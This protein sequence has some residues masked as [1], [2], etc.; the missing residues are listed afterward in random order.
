MSG[1][2]YLVVLPVGL[3]IAISGCSSNP[4]RHIFA[5][6]RDFLSLNE[7]EKYNRE[8]NAEIDWTEESDESP[9]SFREG[10][11]DKVVNVER[12]SVFS[13]SRWLQPKNLAVLPANPFLE[14]DSGAR[15]SDERSIVAVAHSDERFH[16]SVDEFSSEEAEDR[17]F[18]FEE[19]AGTDTRGGLPTLADIMAEFED[20]DDQADDLDELAEAWITGETA[21]SDAVN[22]DPLP[23][24]SN[25][26]LTA[27]KEPRNKAAVWEFDDWDEQ[28]TVEEADPSVSEFSESGNVT[29]AVDELD[30]R[31]EFKAMKAPYAGRQSDGLQSAG[32]LHSEASMDESLWQ[33]ADSSDS[34]GSADFSNDQDNCQVASI[35]AAADMQW[36]WDLGPAT[37]IES[38]ATNPARLTQS[39]GAEGAGIGQ[40][41]GD[42]STSAQ[43]VSQTLMS[44]R[45][46]SP[47]SGV[48]SFPGNAVSQV[49]AVSPAPVT[50]EAPKAGLVSFLSPRAWLMLLGG[51]VIA[52]LLFVPERKNLRH[53]FKWWHR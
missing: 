33:P 50:T 43:Q 48:H 24:K 4:L 52:Y 3:L 38:S 42:S 26:K 53:P 2:K 18:V 15:A 16:G 25:N 1:S 28:L 47:A 7:L 29:G 46:D 32:I 12:K 45:M 13:V 20:Q 35:A 39:F 21:K 30:W 37:E 49:L 34:W 6:D 36:D 9:G 27:S 5:P 44:A 10:A 51:V 8:R 31:L 11:E 40:P 19:T 41:V 14:D 22:F 23:T 17:E